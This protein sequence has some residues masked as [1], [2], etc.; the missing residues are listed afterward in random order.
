MNA[1][2]SPETRRRIDALFA[3][4]ERDTVARL[5]QSECGNNL[6]LLER[7]NEVQLERV[8]FAALKL[9]SGNLKKLH[10]AI[11][12]AK[13]DWRDLLVSAQFADDVNAHSHWFPNKH[14][15]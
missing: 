7:F 13:E 14:D 6:P 11:R 10:D 2:L 15:S 3:Q 1:Q 5:L 8:R 9:S 4:P 12:L